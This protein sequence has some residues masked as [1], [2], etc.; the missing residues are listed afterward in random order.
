M[1]TLGGG[2]RRLGRQ[3]CRHN[4]RLVSTVALQLGIPTARPSLRYFCWETI[5][6]SHLCNGRRAGQDLVFIAGVMLGSWDVTVGGRDGPRAWA[7]E[8]EGFRVGYVKITVWTVNYSA[9]HW[10]KFIKLLPYDRHHSRPRG[11]THEARQ[12]KFL[13]TGCMMTHTNINE[14]N[15]RE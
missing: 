12:K 4:I 14:D 13:L 8:R 2:S 3:L 6:Q 10:T 9:I 5:C 7:S 11:F 15:I 1:S